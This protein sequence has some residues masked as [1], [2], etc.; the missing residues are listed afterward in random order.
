ML[1][2]PCLRRSIN[3]P[4]SSPGGPLG[5]NRGFG[6]IGALERPNGPGHLLADSAI[7]YLEVILRLQVL[8]QL[9]GRSKVAGEAERH[10]RGDR[11]PAPHDLVDRRYRNSELL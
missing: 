6:Q 3:L 4:N 8:P 11:T 1:P 10:F 7:R 5:Q 2:A 9:R